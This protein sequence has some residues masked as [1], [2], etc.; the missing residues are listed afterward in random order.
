MWASM[1]GKRIPGRSRPEGGASENPMETR[2]TNICRA[3][4]SAPWLW[5]LKPDG[6]LRT[7]DIDV[8]KYERALSDSPHVVE[9]R[10]KTLFSLRHADVL[11]QDSVLPEI[12]PNASEDADVDTGSGDTLYEYVN[13]KALEEYA[14]S[15]ADAAARQQARA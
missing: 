7:L 8:G 13:L 6:P 3:A 11:R 12:P 4:A 9:L 5:F 1:L 15:R 10:A 2:R 14:T